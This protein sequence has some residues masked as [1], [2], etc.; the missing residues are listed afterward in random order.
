MLVVAGAVIAVVAL[1]LGLARDTAAHVALEQARDHAHAD[2]HP[3]SAGS[4]RPGQLPRARP[5]PCSQAGLVN[6]LNDALA[7]GLVLLYLGAHGASVGEIGLVAALYP[8]VWSVAQIVTGHRSDRAGR[9]PL[10]AGG[11]LSKP[12]RSRCWHSATARRHPP[13]RP[14]FSGSAPRLST[15][16]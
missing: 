4:V 6:N 3:A 2:H 5:A 16:R 15:R 13:P 10:I 1:L 8:G 9:K 14:R 12:P 11:M 7:W